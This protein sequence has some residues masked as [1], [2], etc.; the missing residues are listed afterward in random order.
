MHPHRG[1][2]WWACLAS[3]LGIVGLSALATNQV[4]AQSTTTGATYTVAINITNSGSADQADIQV[5]LSLSGADL[6]DDG[7]IASDALNAVIQQST[8]DIP[9][10]PPTVRIQVEG[11]VQDDGGTTTEYTTAAQNA[12]LNDIPLLPPAAAVDD[13]FYFGCDNPCGITTWDIDTAGAGTWT[14][15]YEYWDGAAFTAFANVDDRT[16]GFTVAGRHT[17]SWDMPTDWATRTTTGSSV[18]SYWGRARVS[19]FTSETTQP[20]GSRIHYENGQWWTWVED[21]D[22][23][24][25]VHLT[26]HIG[27]TANMV[28][29]HQLF[30]GSTG[31]ITGDA[32]TLEVSG[33]FSIGV[34]GRLDFS[35]AASN[36]C[37][38][39]KTGAITINVSGS[40]STPVIG[41]SIT[42][43]T[44]STG[45]TG[46]ITMPDTGEQTVI[47]AADGINI[48]IFASAGGGMI[49][50]A[51]P[52]TGMTDNGNNWTWASNSGVDYIES[53]RLDAEAPT[54]FNFQTTFTDFN[55]GTH[56]TTQA[57]TGV[58]GLDNQ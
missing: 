21:L 16:M 12:T 26:L 50:F 4:L 23:D 20:L 25:Q 48:G 11:A 58:L 27:G 42:G 46:T 36:A 6:V 49:S 31:I 28:S 2:A 35:A 39:C 18:N 44:T 38:V 54:L 45:D 41:A 53:I 17:T 37:I 7:F 34:F 29:S 30:P 51:L 52:V 55:A 9:S 19:A 32:A 40:A 5:P 13:A 14:L 8:T 15:T 43:D 57:Y 1:L 3:F 56:T 22:V 24:N 47:V 33:A 10:M